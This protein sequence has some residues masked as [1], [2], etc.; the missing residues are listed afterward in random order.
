MAKDIL[1]DKSQAA[2]EYLF[3]HGWMFIIL[4]AVGFSLWQLGIFNFGG[5]AYTAEGFSKLRP[6]L[7]DGQVSAR[8]YTFDFAFANAAGASIL[9]SNG[10]V[11]AKH[12]RHG[13]GQH[14]CH[15][16]GMTSDSGPY[17]LYGD[18]SIP[19]DLGVCIEEPMPVGMNE[20]FLLHAV[21]MCVG[22][23][24]PIDRFRIDISIPYDIKVAGG[25]FRQNTSGVIRGPLPEE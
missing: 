7:A 14:Y 19:C 5:G 4:F 13:I 25:S 15:V 18:P 9:I 11:L 20:V 12:D 2:M 22:G 16:E 8:A 17:L 23:D 3:S 6:V 21:D 10:S 24:F 1:G